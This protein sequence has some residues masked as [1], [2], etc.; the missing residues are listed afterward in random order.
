MDVQ[1]YCLL[2][3]CG[4]HDSQVEKFFHAKLSPFSSSFGVVEVQIGAKN[5]IFG[6]PSKRLNGP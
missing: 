3:E 6:L 4:L 1:L 5:L 2:Q